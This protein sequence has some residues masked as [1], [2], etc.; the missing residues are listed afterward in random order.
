MLLAVV[1]QHGH[2]EDAERVTRMIEARVETQFGRSL[3]PPHT[4]D[5]EVEHQLGSYR[6][7]FRPPY[8]Q[9]TLMLIVFQVLQVVG[10]YGFTSWVPTLLLAQGITV[11]KSLAYTVIIAAANPLGALC[12]T[13][14]ADRCERKWQLALSALSIGE[15]LIERAAREHGVIVRAM[16]RLY[17]EAQPQSA[18]I[19][20]FS[21]YPRQ[22]IA[23]AVARL[24]RAFER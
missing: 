4:L 19:L 2:A 13:Q 8:L 15:A 10:Y 14:F 3:P 6:E 24:A 11:T 16:S 21:G 5:D 22:T 18:L 12:A 9:R 7:I 20:G 17:V 1:C 23:P